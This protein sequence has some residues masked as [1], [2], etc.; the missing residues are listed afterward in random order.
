MPSFSSFKNVSVLCVGDVILDRYISGKARRLSPE[1]P[2]PV[3]SVDSKHDI[4]GGAANVAHNIAAA[5]AK[6]TLS[7]VLGEDASGEA[8]KEAI[9]QYPS[10]SPLLFTSALRK[11]TLKTRVVADHHQ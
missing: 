4:L 6:C 10:L 1:A 8:F 3:V 5:G 11:T 7:G 9:A 2:I